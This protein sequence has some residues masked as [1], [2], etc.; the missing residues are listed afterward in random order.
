[1]RSMH[2]IPVGLD[3]SPFVGTKLDSVC[4]SENTVH[5]QFGPTCSI[6]VDA[7]YEYR[8]GS[9]LASVPEVVPPTTTSVM[10]MV[11]AVVLNVEQ[12]GKGTLVLNLD[13]GRQLKVIE[14]VVPYESYRFVLRGEEVF[15]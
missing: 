4:F 8:L 6:T 5:F 13:N 9:D 12:Q 10:I 7:S 3:L 14:E 2:G 15:V 1:M 11:G